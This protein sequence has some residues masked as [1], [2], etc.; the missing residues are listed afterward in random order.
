MKKII[1]SLSI[2][3]LLSGL[4]FPSCKKDYQNPDLS[5]S[6]EEARKNFLQ[7]TK[8]KLITK[9]EA[10]KHKVEN[11][12]H[13]NTYKEALEY[14]KRDVN[15]KAI[16]VKTKVIDSMPAVI[17]KKI[18]KDY[19]KG[20]KRITDD[21]EDGLESISDDFQTTISCQVA[22]GITSFTLMNWFSQGING[23]VAYRYLNPYD[24]FSKWYFAVEWDESYANFGGYLA[25]GTTGTLSGP[26]DFYV[27]DS[28]GGRLAFS[29]YIAEDVSIGELDYRSIVFVNSSSTFI[30]NIPASTVMTTVTTNSWCDYMQH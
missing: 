29:Y 1:T 14:F 24:P 3:L 2:L 5:A 18:T 19:Q 8:F 10:S 13:F 12:M 22:G 7:N 16:P 17:K 4:F 26:Y 20:S 23:A 25:S 30:T 21:L 15:K 27:S 6:E 28:F 9:E 11:I